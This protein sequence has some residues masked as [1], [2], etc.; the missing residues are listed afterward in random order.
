MSY[1]TNTNFKKGQSKGELV[2]VVLPDETLECIERIY[3]KFGG[4]H[5]QFSNTV[6]T[7]MYV[8]LKNNFDSNLDY[9]ACKPRRPQPKMTVNKARGK[10]PQ[11][12]VSCKSG[13]IEKIDKLCEKNNSNRSAIMRMLICIAIQYNYDE[14]FNYKPAERIDY[15]AREQQF[16]DCLILLDEI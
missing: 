10:N 5:R 16:R 2:G 13:L 3:K 14:H 4:D 8:A 9:I 12:M 7:L 6:R 15:S 1:N 11:K